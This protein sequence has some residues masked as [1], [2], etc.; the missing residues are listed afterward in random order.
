MQSRSGRLLCFY[1]TILGSSSSPFQSIVRCRDD[2]ACGFRTDKKQACLV[3]LRLKPPAHRPRSLGLICS[4]KSC[5]RGTCVPFN[6]PLSMWKRTFLDYCDAMT[7]ALQ[8]NSVDIRSIFLI[9]TLLHSGF[10]GGPTEYGNPFFLVPIFR[11]FQE[12]H[13][14]CPPCCS[15]SFMTTSVS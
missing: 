3:P 5:P 1:S 11:I 7:V 4:W 13:N 15:V 6:S 14:V 2:D 10:V 8:C 12:C 9:L